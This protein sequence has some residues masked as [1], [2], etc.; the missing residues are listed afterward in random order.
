MCQLKLKLK[1]PHDIGKSTGIKTKERKEQNYLQ[2]EYIY[3]YIFPCTFAQFS[4]L[5]YT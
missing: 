4:Q 2:D 5:W 1:I 3:I